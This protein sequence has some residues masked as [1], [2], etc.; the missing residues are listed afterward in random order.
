MLVWIPISNGAAADDLT[1]RLT[2]QMEANQQRYGIAGQAV[3]VTHNGRMLFRHVSGRADV[4][5]GKRVAP[6][7]I[8]PVYSLSKLFASTLI[9][10]LVEQGEIDLDRP[11]SAYLSDL[12]QRWNAITVRQLLNHASGLPEYFTDAQMSGTAEAN[13][14]FPASVNALFSTLADKA[15]VFAPGTE[16]R[17]TQTN[18]VVLAHLLETHYGKPYA[19]IATERIIDRLHL[20]HTYLGHDK[21]PKQGVVTAYLGKSDKLQKQPDIAWPPYAL[22]HASLYMS[23]G[24]LATF[25]QAVAAGELVG[26]TTLQRLWQPQSAMTAARACECGFCSRTRWTA[27]STP[28][29]T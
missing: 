15:P 4:D 27:T 1:G 9:L 2:R 20:T 23:I 11:A 25:L 22:G 28:S 10:Q 5:S 24:D 18:Y 7:D 16:T 8:F 3:Q 12:P 29:S 17:Y 13:A 19:Q 26:K 21:L 14:S 6:D